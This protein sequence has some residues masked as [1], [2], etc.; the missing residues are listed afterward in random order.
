MR[1]LCTLFIA[2]STLCLHSCSKEV[3]EPVDRNSLRPILKV[4]PLNDQLVVELDNN[5]TDGER[6]IWL[7]DYGVPNLD[8]SKIELFLTL[9][10]GATMYTPY[11]KNPISLDYTLKPEYPNQV[12]TAYMNG[13]YI[14]YRVIM[15]SVQAITKVEATASGITETYIT[16][17]APLSGSNRYFNFSFNEQQ[18][19]L[20]KTHLKFELSPRVSMAST[21]TII[22]LTYPIELPIY[23]PLGTEFIEIDAS[24]LY[25][26]PSY[27]PD[28]WTHCDD[29]GETIPL[30]RASEL[31]GTKCNAYMAFE[32]NN[33][34]IYRPT[35][36]TPYWSAAKLFSEFYQFS[37]FT[38]FKVSHLM[39]TS[40][41]FCFIANLI[42]GKSVIVSADES[43][44][45]KP[46][47]YQDREGESDTG[48]IQKSGD[49]YTV[50][51]IPLSKAIQGEY[52]LCQNSQW[53]E[54]P[55][56][57]KPTGWNVIASTAKNDIILFSCECSDE[58]PGLT[59]AQLREV[60]FDLRCTDALI[61]ERG[62]MLGMYAD[63]KNLIRTTTADTNP[64]PAFYSG[65]AVGTDFYY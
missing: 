3:E 33:I 6:T 65:I 13:E 53:Q 57:G 56:D 2:I 63:S 27:I 51:G 47:F 39:K 44:V 37:I 1:H 10:E 46:A 20:S 21:D 17:D 60:L 5:E 64:D 30:F 32:W 26:R 25:H 34:T 52:I 42:E 50:D 58:Y 18:V 40:S 45:G 4:I 23:T 38:P 28:Y 35:G 49:S 59:L 55:D 8:Y 12:I 61:T 48:L 14:Y 9:A 62:E 15:Q 41:S 43:S 24:T 11:D 7:Y 31:E 22:D 36:S 19:D 29:L 54:L 16:S